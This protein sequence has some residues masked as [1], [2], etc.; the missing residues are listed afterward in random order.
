MGATSLVLH[1]QMKQAKHKNSQA[2]K[3]IEHPTRVAAAGGG[4]DNVAHSCDQRV[5]H[6]ELLVVPIHPLTHRQRPQRHTKARQ[7]SNAREP[8]AWG[9]ERSA[10]A[11]ERVCFVCIPPVLT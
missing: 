11:R 2:R 8:H 5:E 10:E 6:N 1:C 7:Q 4:K 9:R 3:E